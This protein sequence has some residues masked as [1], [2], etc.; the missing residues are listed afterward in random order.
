MIRSG[1]PS[2]TPKLLLFDIDG[3]LMLSHGGG[4]RAMTAAA[5]RV[6]RPAFS[7]E[8]IDCNGRL[9]PDIVLEALTH[10]G[11]EGSTPE[12][13]AAFRRHYFELLPA[14]LHS[15]R[16]LPGVLELLDR[17]RQT[18]E[19]LLGLVTGNYQ[20]SGRIKL[21]SVGIDP[22]WFLI[23]GFAECAETRPG[24]VRWAMDQ[25]SALVGRPLDALETIVIGDTPRDVACAKANGC[26]A[27]AVAT[28][29]YDIDL[30]RATEADLVLPDFTD[31]APLWQML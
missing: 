9:D 27:V 23:N 11:V 3:T 21:A 25:G 18:E 13:V 16:A 4:I 30:L 14:E 2:R 12:Q 29:N 26:L 24:I 10:N 6:F 19:V 8:A 28:G 1:V 31:S 22:Q 15:A 5:C 17:L 7:M 20:E